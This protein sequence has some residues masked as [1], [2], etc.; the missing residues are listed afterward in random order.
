MTLT[1]NYD[2]SSYQQP[3]GMS[4]ALLTELTKPFHR[5]LLDEARSSLTSGSTETAT[6]LAQAASE[7]CTEWAITGLFAL[8]KDGDLTEAVLGLFVAKDICNERVRAVFSALSNDNPAQQ[9]FWTTLKAHHKRRNLVV[10]RGS[11]ASAAEA[12]ESVVTVEQYIGYV[13]ALLS[14]RQPKT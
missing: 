14:S 4:A 10:H 12:Q 9:P 7:M 3:R 11:K 13:E 5:K 8:R 6:V 1:S 2:P